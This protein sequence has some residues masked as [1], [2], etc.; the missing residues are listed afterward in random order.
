MSIQKMGERKED[1]PKLSDGG[2]WRVLWFIALALGVRDLQA[3]ILHQLGFDP[4]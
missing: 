4:Y 3:T 1:D 2:G